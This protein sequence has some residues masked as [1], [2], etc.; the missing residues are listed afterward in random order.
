MSRTVK[1]RAAML[2]LTGFT[3]GTLTLPAAA[4]PTA[5]TTACPTG[6][7][8]MAETRPAATTMP[9]ANVRTGRHTCYDR[10]VIDVAGA[11]SGS[12]GYSVRYVSRLVQDGS[13]R[14][15]PIRA[16]AVLEI[17][18]NAPAYDLRTGKPTYPAKPGHSLPRV[19]LAGYR[20][21]RAVKYGVSFEGQTQF[22]LGVRARLPFRV[23]VL[24][25]R[26]VVDVEHAWR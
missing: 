24:D 18:I 17:V 1:D 5:L 3:L 15:I 12:L 20:T 2:A 9:V 22:G 26:A 25:G 10:I 16:G 7:G 23:T 21:F 19:N 4:V 6:W 8:S 13:G 11:K 14:T